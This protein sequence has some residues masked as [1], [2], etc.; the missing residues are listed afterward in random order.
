MHWW[1]DW[2]ETLSFKNYIRCIKIRN[3]WNGGIGALL[4]FNCIFRF[5]KDGGI[6]Y[7][8]EIDPEELINEGIVIHFRFF[9]WTRITNLTIHYCIHATLMS[10]LETSTTTIKVSSSH[11]PLNLKIHFFF[12]NNNNKSLLTLW[13]NTLDEM[14]TEKGRIKWVFLYFYCLTKK[15]HIKSN[16][17]TFSTYLTTNTRPCD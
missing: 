10:P 14:I 11:P 9:P 1:N 5:T 15:N 8:S 4:S 6:L 7:Y 12:N 16:A 17:I 3:D 13:F 2:A